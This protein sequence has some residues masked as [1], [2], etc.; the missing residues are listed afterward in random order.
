MGAPLTT[1]V[2]KPHLQKKEDICFPLTHR[3]QYKMSLSEKLHFRINGRV[4]GDVFK[5]TL[6]VSE[7]V[8]DVST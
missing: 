5:V 3:S 8:V 1:A 7:F 6:G 2:R 4:G